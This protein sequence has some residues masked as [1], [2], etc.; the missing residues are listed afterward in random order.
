M[1][2]ECSPF[3]SSLNDLKLLPEC[4]KT[5]LGRSPYFFNFCY[6]KLNPIPCVY[7]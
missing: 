5:N 6:L 7:I 1:S 2:S 3:F 4:Y